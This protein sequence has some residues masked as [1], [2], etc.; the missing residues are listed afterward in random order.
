MKAFADL[1]LRNG[2][3]Y[4]VD[5]KRSWASAVAIRNGRYIAIGDDAAVDPHKGPSTEIVDLAG[6]MAMPGITDIHTHMMMGGQ[7][8]LFDLNFASS[9]GVDGICAAVRAWAEKAAARRLDR[10]GAMGQ[11]QAADA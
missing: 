2:R 7:A 5:D 6:R 4:T 1:I 3:I 8:E 9:L 11:R 10:R